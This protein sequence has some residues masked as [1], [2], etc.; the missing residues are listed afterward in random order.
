MM[1]GERSVELGQLIDEA[2]LSR[3]QIGVILLCSLG[4]FTDGYDMQAIG[5]AAPE[6]ARELSVAPTQLGLSFSA[7]VVGM[8]LGSLTL[9][10]LADRFGR[11]PLMIA[12]MFLMGIAS[13]AT[14]TASR[15]TELM[16]W[17][18]AT[19]LGLGALV[20]IAITL[21]AEFV[22]TRRRAALVTIMIGTISIGA[23]VASIVAPLIIAHFGWRGIFAIGGIVPIALGILYCFILPE[24]PRTLLHRNPADP[25]LSRLLSRI[26]GREAPPVHLAVRAGEGKGGLPLL[27]SSEF[28]GRTIL[29]W[30][31]WALNLFVNFALASWLPTFLTSA[32]WA[33]A[34]ALRAVGIMAS[35]GLLGG[36]LMSWLVDKGYFIRPL[37][38]AYLI[39]AGA[40]FG[41][42]VLPAQH[43]G[44][45]IAAI[46]V[47]AFGSQLTIG[48]VAA[49][50][51][52]AAIRATGLGWGG[53]V[54]RVGS[55]I[56]PSAFG[57]MVA[58]GATTSATLAILILPM[59]ICAACVTVMG[60]YVGTAR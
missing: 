46:G 11:R 21:T 32:G 42:T 38:I 50:F 8:A 14:A 35:G 33:Q 27:F 41:F 44:Y 43:W 26:L 55:I 28:V 25:G 34:D 22:P 58:A 29:L 3:T 36:V 24:S 53:G 20:P 48:A 52:P 47:G 9:G 51:Y 18:F 17:R 6:L 39:A 7:G 1:V 12:M 16:A 40:L 54:G 23:I 15:L 2:P 19:G 5:L 13:I 31:V 30:L 4:I 57:L 37:M 49:T 60:R 10:P 56:G 59:L 45:L